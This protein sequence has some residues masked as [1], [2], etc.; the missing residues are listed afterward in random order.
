MFKVITEVT[1]ITVDDLK[2]PAASQLRG[3]RITVNEVTRADL[4]DRDL[5]M[6]SSVIILKHKLQYSCVK[7]R[8]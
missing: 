2:E 4:K 7:S 6:I 8:Y 3:N 5:C 1:Y